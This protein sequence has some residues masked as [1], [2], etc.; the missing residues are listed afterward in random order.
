MRSILHIDMNNFYAFSYVF[1]LVDMALGKK[2]SVCLDLVFHAVI[3]E[4]GG[5][6]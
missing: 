1:G 3:G 6:P 5:F 4:P 2:V